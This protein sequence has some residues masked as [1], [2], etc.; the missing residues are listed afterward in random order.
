MILSMIQSRKKVIRRIK[1]DFIGAALAKLQVK[2]NT[3]GSSE[4]SAS[5]HQE[6]GEGLPTAYYFLRGQAEIALGRQEPQG[7]EAGDLILVP[8]GDK[9]T[10]TSGRHGN[11]NNGTSHFLYATIQAVTGGE[12]PFISALPSLLLL[13]PGSRSLSPYLETQLQSLVWEANTGGPAS[14]LL[15]SRLWE[16]VFLLAFRSYLS[17]ATQRHTTGW[18]AAIRDPQLTGVLGAIQ[19][20]PNGEW[21]VNR[22][23]KLAAMS[24]A[25]F[26]RQFTRM[27]G[28]PPMRFLYLLR[29]GVAASL[30][31]QGECNLATVATRVGYGSEAAFSNAFRRHFDCAPGVYRTRNA[32]PP[33]K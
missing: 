13:K 22:M 20:Q 2:A 21:T 27:M 1:M 6:R 5:W 19:Q 30:L 8:H 4:V 14:E 12:C 31:K 26:L 33:K 18:L 24:R 29:M 11:R 17:E 3:V 16:V 23:A 15:L 25:T 9:H 28:E 32:S 7:I 10:L